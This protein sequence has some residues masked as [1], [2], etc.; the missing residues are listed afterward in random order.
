MIESII[1]AIV[2]LGIYFVLPFH[3]IGFFV[4]KILDFK[5]NEKTN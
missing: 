4:A 3:I 1:N 5:R 2:I